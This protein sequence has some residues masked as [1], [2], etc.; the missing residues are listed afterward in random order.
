[1]TAPVGMVN[2]R[3]LVP[4]EAWR[5]LVDRGRRRTYQRGS[6]LLRQGESPDSV[7]ALVEGQVRVS[8]LN[9]RG[10]E[11]VLMLRGPGELLGEMGI[12]V[13]R[14]RSASVTAAQRCVGMVL[15]AHAFRG[16]VDR[17]GLQAVI[18]QLTVERLNSHERLRVGLLHSSPVARIASVVSLLAE[19][20][21]RP[22]GDAVVVDLGVARAELAAMAAMKRSSAAAALRSLQAAGVLSLARRRLIV[23]DPGQ[24][25]AAARGEAYG[26]A[27]DVL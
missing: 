25:A 11:L 19:E 2:F 16:Y 17:H 14:P 15:P 1:M 5:D 22:D 26:R 3:S 20:L 9:E 8:Q 6:L 13:G 4:P 12:L 24:L 18:Y 27:P 21:G 23:T 10:D 7:I